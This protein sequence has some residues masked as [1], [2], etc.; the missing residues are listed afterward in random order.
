VERFSVGL[1]A[2]VEIGGPTFEAAER[3]DTGGLFLLFCGGT[4][5]W[6]Q[7]RVR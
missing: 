6:I 1:G 5:V 4:K 2:E 7:K 3:H